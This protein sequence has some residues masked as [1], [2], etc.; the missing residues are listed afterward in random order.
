M[1]EDVTVGLMASH[2][3][4]RSSIQTAKKS[5]E[6]KTQKKVMEDVEKV[7]FESK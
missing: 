5:N 3:F 7:A 1:V 2:P 4:C 6:V